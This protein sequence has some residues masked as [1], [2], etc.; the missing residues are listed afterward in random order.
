M[1]NFDQEQL[2][3]RAL[4][5]IH[6]QVLPGREPQR[7]WGGPGSGQHCALCDLPVTAHQNEYQIEADV[8]GVLTTLRFH[9]VCKFAWRL[10]CARAQ[11]KQRRDA[12]S[13]DQSPPDYAVHRGHG[14]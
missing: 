10:A 5:R 4:K 13:S 2:V 11:F 8:N 6:N 7:Y 3:D 1:S 12:D 14:S 9:V